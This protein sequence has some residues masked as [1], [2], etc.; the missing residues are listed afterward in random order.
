ML[1]GQ[2]LHP[3]KHALQIFTDTSKEGWGAYLNEY[4]ARETWSLPESKLHL[5]YLE[6][7]AVLLALKEFQD[8]CSDKI[9]LVATDNTAVV[10]K[11]GRRHEVGPTFCPTVE[12]LD[13]VYQEISDSQSLTHS[14]PA[15]HGS[16]QAIQA[17]PDHPDRVVPP[18][19]G[20]PNDIQQVAHTSNRS[21][22]HEVQQQV[23]SV[24]V[25][26][27]RTPVLSSGCTQSALGGSRHIC[28][29]T[30]SHIGQSSGEVAG[31]PMHENH[32]DA[33]P[34]QLVETV[35]QS[36]ASQKSDKSESP[37]MGPRA[38]A[39]KQQGFSEAVAA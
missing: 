28:L 26:G 38:S 3:I 27:T 10:Y 15:E 7:K 13:L 2:P 34:A 18:S 24:C 1:Q 16:R 9:V 31:L 33:Q 39:I 35:L 12:N 22:C 8:L 17:R 30:S 4:T 21:I 6:L 20:I 5:N 14:R 11:Q 25:T 37:C 23:T 36:D 32:S 29:P 19:R